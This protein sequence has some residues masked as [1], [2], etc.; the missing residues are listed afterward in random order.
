VLCLFLPLR[1]LLPF[2]FAEPF[3]QRAEDHQ[4]QCGP[5]GEF[6][7]PDVEGID[8]DKSPAVDREEEEELTFGRRTI[9]EKVDEGSGLAHGS[10]CWSVM[11]L[12]D[13]AD[14]AAIWATELTEG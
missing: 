3:G 7:V 1:R 11:D 14:C 2:L 10:G 13:L 5:V 6:I 8:L 12:L 4:I 9:G